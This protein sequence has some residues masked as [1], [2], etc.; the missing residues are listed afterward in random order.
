[1]NFQITWDDAAFL[2]AALK[3]INGAR[4]A[5]LRRELVEKMRDYDAESCGSS[6]RTM[7]KDI[8]NRVQFWVD[9]IFG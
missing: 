7:T 3:P 2:I 8:R 5:E 4:A 1:M 9:R 6:P